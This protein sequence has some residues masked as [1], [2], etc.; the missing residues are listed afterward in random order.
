MTGVRDVEKRVEGMRN[1]KDKADGAREADTTALTMERPQNG[2]PEDLREHAQLMFDIIAMAFQ[3]D[4]TRV[5]SLL[6]A[7]DLSTLYYPFLDVREV[8]T[9]RR[10]TTSRTAT[11]GSRAST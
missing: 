2:L 9:A 6:L 5:A 8:I 3:T 1:D 10:T 4:K 7:R 11:S